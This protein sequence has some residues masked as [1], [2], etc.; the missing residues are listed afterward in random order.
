MTLSW[1]ELLLRF[2]I[3][4]VVVVGATFFAEQKSPLW[5][6]LINNFPALTMTSLLILVSVSSGEAAVK[7]SKE[8]LITLPV[9]IAFLAAFVVIYKF[10]SSKTILFAGSLTVWFIAASLFL[11]TNNLVKIK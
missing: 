7:L 6:G 2:I 5:S 8:T 9:Y 3:G 11:Y 4:G 1:L 10:T